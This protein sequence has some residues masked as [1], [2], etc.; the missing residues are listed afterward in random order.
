MGFFK[1]ARLTAEEQA[2]RDAVRAARSALKEAEGTYAKSVKEA[3]K[4][5]NKTRKTHESAVKS[6]EKRL[7]QAGHKKLGT[8]AGVTLFDDWI[9]TPQGSGALTPAV[10]AMCDTAGAIEKRVTATRLLTTGIFAFAWKKK[11]DNRE[12]YLLV[13]HPEFMSAQRVDPKQ[14]VAARQFAASIT[15]AARQIETTKARIAREKAEAASNLEL[16][17]A[18]VSALETAEAEVVRV[19]SDTE[20][21]DQRRL[22]LEQIAPAETIAAEALAAQ[23]C[24]ECPHCRDEMRR[25]ASV[26]PHCERD[27]E[28]RGRS[29][30]ATGGA[31][32]MTEAGYTWTRPQG[33]GAFW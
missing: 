27:S 20:L 3:Q 7:A 4:Q 31:T 19:T 8:L 21:V 18:N 5:L 1:R 12:L 11:T 14:G 13:D 6:A 26:C 10:T 23:A 2:S 9:D 22:E 33:S 25:D 32:A 15:T 30:K 16:V 29:T 17:K 24:R 28:G